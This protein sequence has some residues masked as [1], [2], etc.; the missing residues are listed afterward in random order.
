MLLLFDRQKGKPVAVEV[1][2]AQN[3]Y[4]FLFLLLCESSTLFSQALKR[5]VVQQCRK[6]TNSV[7][8]SS[9]LLR[10][11]KSRSVNDLCALKS[12]VFNTEIE[13]PRE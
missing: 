10:V 7:K 3:S 4:F 6:S 11:G 5:I 9:S 13:E 2:A 1:S 12:L 8:E